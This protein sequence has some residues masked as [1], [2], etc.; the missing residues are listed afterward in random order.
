MARKTFTVMQRLKSLSGQHV[1]WDTADSNKTFRFNSRTYTIAASIIGAQTK[2]RAGVIMTDEIIGWESM[3]GINSGYAGKGIV[4]YKAEP[5]LGSTH[6]ALSGDVRGFEASLGAPSGGGTIAGVISGMKFIN[7]AAK[8]PTGGVY[9]LYAL[10][11][12]DVVAWDGLANLPDDGQ[13]A[14]Y[15]QALAGSVYSWIKVKIG[16]TTTYVQCR[17]LA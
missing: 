1:A 8:A 6:G 4:C 11:H 7:N 3:P 16:T 5:Y 15:N 14:K 12:G 17:S 13:L 2:P 10:T 9:M